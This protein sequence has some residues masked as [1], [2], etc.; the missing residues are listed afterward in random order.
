MS[1]DAPVVMRTLQFHG[2][3]L[4]AR[5]WRRRSIWIGS[6]VAVV[7][8]AALFGD[9]LRDDRRPPR[10]DPQDLQQVEL[11]RRLYAQHCAS[12]HG[13]NLEGQPEWQS[14]KPDGRLPAPPH[15]ASGHT[16]HHDDATLF[17][18]TKLG[19]DRV[20]GGGYRSDMPG[21]EVTLTDAEIVAALAY[22]KS[23]WPPDIQRRQTMIDARARGSGS[24]E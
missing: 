21:F 14:R 23:R 20:V 5:R 3:A 6:A 19:T 9:H 7:V 10:I 11:G 12:C 24:N 17:R 15:D 22:I 2:R 4:V 16:W 1:A 13:G 8:G 18:V